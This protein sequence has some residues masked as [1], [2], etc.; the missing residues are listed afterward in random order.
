LFFPD[1]IARPKSNRTGPFLSCSHLHEFKSFKINEVPKTQAAQ[2]NLNA[3]TVS[4]FA[5]SIKSI[6]T[7]LLDIQPARAH[8]TI[9]MM[10]QYQFISSS[11]QRI[12]QDRH[13]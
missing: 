9:M 8:A 4:L 11:N 13:Q 5:Q 6:Q 1:G 3:F 2:I 7:P 12:I 10:L